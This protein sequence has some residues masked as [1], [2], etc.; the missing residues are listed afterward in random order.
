MRLRSGV[1]GMSS[2]TCQTVWQAVRCV[3]IPRPETRF[4]GSRYL[5][6]WLSSHFIRIPRVT[7]SLKLTQTACYIR[8]YAPPK[9]PVP[10]TAT[11]P[12]PSPGATPSLALSPFQKLS[13][14]GP[15]GCWADADSNTYLP[16]WSRSLVAK[17]REPVT[18]TLTRSCFDWRAVEGAEISGCSLPCVLAPARLLEPET[19]WRLAP[20]RAG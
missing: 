11:P 4:V 17:K 8:A 13:R 19:F 5:Y 2:Q 1:D 3:K 15:S 9:A 12:Q 20:V 7:S 6:F 18:R 16:C 10:P 14:G